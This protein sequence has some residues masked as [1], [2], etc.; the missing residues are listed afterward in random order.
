MPKKTSRRRSTPTP[1]GA[2]PTE[3]PPAVEAEEVNGSEAAQYN[4]YALMDKRDA[5]QIVA[6]ITGQEI[7]ELLYLIPFGVKDDDYG[8]KD[9]GSD[10]HKVC[11]YCRKGQK[12]HV[13]VVGVSVTGIDE[14]ARI[15]QGIQ[16]AIIETKR[17]HRDGKYWWISRAAALDSFTVSGATA[18]AEQPC[19]MRRGSEDARAD[20]D[21]VI[22]ERK[23]ER[24]AV[25]KLLPQFFLAGL[26]KMAWQ[27]IKTFEAKDVKRLVTSLG[28]DRSNMTPRAS[29]IPG[30]VALSAGGRMIPVPLIAEES[31]SEP[32]H[33]TE[34]K[35]PPTGSAPPAPSAPLTPSTPPPSTNGEP[36]KSQ[37]ELNRDRLLAWA[38]REGVEEAETVLALWWKSKFGKSL[39]DTTSEEME[40]LGKQLITFYD[41]LAETTADR[42]KRFSELVH[43]EAARARAEG[44][45]EELFS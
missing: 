21:R 9:Y 11:S 37:R 7:S 26:Q 32:P 28:E 45:S 38:Q 18:S 8:K 42:Q 39:E 20:L 41:G 19:I 29:L 14:V 4:P 5:D 27:G 24:N 23:A 6:G 1:K 25:R 34:G 12:K 22:A 2:A 10:F 13:H 43:A 30:M 40:A 36:P 44:K 3:K 31:S 33:I 35:T 16:R 15:Y 17:I